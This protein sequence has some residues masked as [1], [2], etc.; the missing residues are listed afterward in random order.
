MPSRLNASLLACGLLAGGALQAQSSEYPLAINL[1]TVDRMQFWDLGVT[2]THRFAAP[3]KDHGKDAYGLDGLAYAGFGIALGFK[4]IKGLNLLA[5]RTAD[6]KTF[7]IGFQQQLMDKEYFRMAFRAERFDEVV[8]RYAPPVGSTVSDATAYERGVVGG[9]FQ[10]PMEIFLPGDVFQVTLVPTYLTRTTT[11]NYKFNQG[12]SPAYLPAEGKK[13][14]GVFN[15]AL[16]VRVNFTE[17]FGWITEYYPKPS[18]LP[19]DTFRSG[20]A[21]G[22]TYKTFKHRFTLTATNVHGTTA[23]QVLGGDYDHYRNAD[24]TD[25]AGPWPSSQWSLGFNVSRVF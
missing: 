4:P 18:R 12:A 5:Y 8:D 22:I 2:F 17:A 6:N 10:V 23:N 3:V 15:C 21:T 16:G 13:G 20:F 9:S 11:S 25:G 19:S 1:P 24:G 7:T 14:S